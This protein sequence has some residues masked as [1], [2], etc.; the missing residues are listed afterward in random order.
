MRECLRCQPAAP[1][2]L[3]PTVFVIQ[4]VR[5]PPS[6]VMGRERKHL[7]EE[8]RFLP[9]F[10]F[11]YWPRTTKSI[12]PANPPL[13]WVHTIPTNTQH[14]S[15]RALP[16]HR[17][18]TG[19]NTPRPQWRR[20]QS[21]ILVGPAHYTSMY[22]ATGTLRDRRGD[23][24]VCYCFWNCILSATQHR[25]QTAP[26]KIVTVANIMQFCVSKEKHFLNKQTPH[27]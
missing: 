3:K 16:C 8:H 7:S 13:R 1:V 14:L 21:T 18:F 4:S 20:K 17:M 2:N 11:C 12:Q 15:L 27:M 19:Y 26:S 5:E 6:L 9:F 23:M 10:F 25:G 22:G 24:T